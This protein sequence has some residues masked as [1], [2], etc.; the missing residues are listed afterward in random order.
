MSKS[1]FEYALIPAIIEA[2]QEIVRDLRPYL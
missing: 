2:A 1:I